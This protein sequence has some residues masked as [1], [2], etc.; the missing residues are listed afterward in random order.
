MVKNIIIAVLVLLLADVA[1]IVYSSDS[2]KAELRARAD[3]LEAWM[4]GQYEPRPVLWGEAQAGNAWQLYE[5]A[6]GLVDPSVEKRWKQIVWEMEPG[7]ERATLRDALLDQHAEAL[8]KMSLGAHR[9]DARHLIRWKEG[10]S[11]KV[12]QIPNLYWFRFLSNLAVLQSERY[13]DEG[14]PR[15]AVHVLLDAM[16]FGRD[17][18]EKPRMIDELIGAALLNIPTTGALIQFEQLDRFPAAELQ[19]LADGMAILDAGLPRRSL[20][21]SGDLLLFHRSILQQSDS[22][23]FQ[24]QAWL[25]GFSGWS[26]LASQVE[27]VEFL[28]EEQLSLSEGPWS[29]QRRRCNQSLEDFLESSSQ[30]AIAWA[31]ALGNASSR[32]TAIKNLRLSRMA[33]MLRLDGQVEPIA[34]PF[35]DLLSYEQQGEKLVIQSLGPKEDSSEKDRIEITVKPAAPSGR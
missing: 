4:D 19:E 13:L 22:W 28:V 18:L 11:Q 33:V 35:G 20:G 23:W 10:H 31:P 26:M 7:E 17:L 25:H 9:Q 27:E 1:W 8:E 16:Q 21:S 29:E 14:K 34:D 15:Q 5:E 32:L 3:R 12:D 24:G 6:V 2:A 30:V